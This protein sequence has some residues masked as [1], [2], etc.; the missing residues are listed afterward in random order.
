M[1]C[2]EEKGSLNKRM[3]W[4]VECLVSLYSKIKNYSKFSWVGVQEKLAQEEH[5][6]NCHKFRLTVSYYTTGQL[7]SNVFDFRSNVTY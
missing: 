4:L 6:V 3:L 5:A 2:N 7:P 1:Q